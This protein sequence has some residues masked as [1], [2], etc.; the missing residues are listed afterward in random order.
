MART[1]QVGVLLSGCGVFDGAEIHESVIALLALD[2]AGARAVC[3][4]PN[5]DQMHVVNH[6]TGEP[7]DERRNVLDEAAR[8]ARG[9][10]TDLAE[11]AADDLDA[12]LLPGGFGAAK[13]LS[14][15]AVAGGL[16]T[17]HPEVTRIL[18][19]MLAAR[20]PIG[21]ICIAPAVLAAVLRDAGEACQLT[22]GDD[23]DT[24][25]ALAT[26]GVHHVRCGVA[27]V[28]VDRERRVV[29]TPAYMLAGRISEA[30]AGID[31]LVATLLELV[32]TRVPS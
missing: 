5:V 22:I 4:A 13:N 31:K 17:V 7:T 6:R 8:I 11:L 28:C 19:E 18:R 25:D 26:M 29:S 16:A 10:I 3:T 30:A 20:K 23:A 15:F 12:L 24:A 2:R 32:A 1:P 21:V 27:D 14:D 9:E